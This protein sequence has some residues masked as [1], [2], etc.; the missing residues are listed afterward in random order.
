ME[1]VHRDTPFGPD[2]KLRMRAG[3]SSAGLS[4]ITIE[5]SCGQKRNLGDVFRFDEK[6]GGP[7]SKLGCYC[8]GLRPWLGE[9]D[10]G[11]AICTGSRHLRVLQRGA[12]NVYFP[13]VVSSIYLPLWAEHAGADVIS[14]LVEPKSA[15][16]AVW[17]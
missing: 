7:L 6:E 4:G 17:S 15:C 3:R 2:C 10:A 16:T 14:A 8:K 9:A 12:S 11:A 1:W 13:Q 5:C